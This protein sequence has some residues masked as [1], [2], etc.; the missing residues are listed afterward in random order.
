MQFYQEKFISEICFLNHSRSFS[1]N[2]ASESDSHWREKK[3]QLS[4]GRPSV[5]PS[6]HMP[7]A[8]ATLRLTAGTSSVSAAGRVAALE[9]VAY[10][11]VSS[12][13][14]GSPRARGDRQRRGEVT[15]WLLSH[16][17]A[18]QTHCFL[19]RNTH[20]QQRMENPSSRNRQRTHSP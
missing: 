8:V 4:A 1:T 11:A 19:R 13:S 12:L 16:S 14:D 2:K 9:S 15:A 17:A 6:V 7:A 18:V 20:L 5:R 10:H 3:Q